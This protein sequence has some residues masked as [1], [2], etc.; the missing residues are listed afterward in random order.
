[1]VNIGIIVGSTRPRRNAEA[2]ARWVRE[3]A[4]E[5]TDAA[6]ELIDISDFNLPLFDEPLSPFAVALMKRDYAL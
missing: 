6:F 5:R 4:E 3:I 1:V 2:V